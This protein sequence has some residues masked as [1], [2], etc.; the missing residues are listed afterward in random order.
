MLPARSQPRVEGL[1]RTAAFWTVTL[2][3]ILCTALGC[4][5]LDA[6]RLS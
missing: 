2:V 4:I 5:S 3:V 1:V 6:A